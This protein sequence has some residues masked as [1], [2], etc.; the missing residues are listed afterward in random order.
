MKKLILG[1]AVAAAFLSTPAYAFDL[2]SIFGNAGDTVSGIVDGLLTTSDITVAQMAGTWTATGS[3]VCFQSEN[4]LQKAGGSAAASTIES[5]LNPYFKQYGLTGAVLTID[6]S[7]KFSLKV[8]GVTLSGTI[9]KRSDGNF[10][11]KFQA[12]GSISLGSIKTYVEKSTSGLNVMFDASKLKSL[13][14]A[15]TSLTGNSLAQTAG[16]LL[17]SYQGLCVGFKFT[18]S[19]TSSGSNNSN[20]NSNSSEKSGDVE[21]VTNALK[22]LFGK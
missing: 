12:L 8:K 20:G 6:Q 18:G 22:G 19:G 13:I 4:L 17:D 14:T 21:R 16:S 7:G 5:K 15:I 3:A 1:V 2:K 11:F 10:D 9:T